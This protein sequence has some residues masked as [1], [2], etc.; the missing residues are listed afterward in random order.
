MRLHDLLDAVDPLELTGDSQVDVSDIVH[1]SRR[2]T[3]GALFCCIRGTAHDGHDHAAAAVERGAV[4]LLVERPVEVPVT[5]ARVGHV[6][7][8]LGPI[9]ARFFG[10]PSRA[11]RV[12]GVTGTNGKTT[13]TYLLEAI[14]IAA[15]ERVGVIG[16]TGARIDGVEEPLELTTPEAPQLQSL[17]ARMHRAR[18]GT[19]A[20]EVSSHALA[21]E[22]VDGSRF[23]AVCFTNLS[24]DHLDEHRTLAEYFEAKARLFT[25]AFTD[26]VTIGLDDRW[27]TELATRAQGAGLDVWTFGLD[28]RASV[29]GTARQLDADGSTIQLETSSGATETIRIPLVGLFNVQNALAAAAT[30]LAS[31][32]PLDAVLAGLQ[33][34]LVVPGRMERVTVGQPFTVLVDYAHTPGALERLVA[35]SRRLAGSNRVL[36]VFGCGGDR[37][38]TKRAAMGSAAADADLVVLTSDNP[39]SEEPAAI[40]AAAE[41][42]LRERD[43]SYVVELDRRQAIRHALG[44]ARANDVVVIAGKGHETGQEIAGVVTPFDDRVVAR[45]ELEALAGPDPRRGRRDHL[46]AGT[47]RPGRCPGSASTRGRLHAGLGSSRSEPSATVTTSSPTRSSRRSF[48]VVERFPT[49]SDGTFVVRWPTRTRRFGARC[50]GARPAGRPTVVGI[51]G[52]AGKT[53]TKDL[54]APRRSGRP[55]GARQRGVVQQRDR[56]SGDVARHPARHRGRRRRDGGALRREHHRAVHDRPSRRSVSSPTSASPTPSTSAAPTASPG[57]GRARRGAPADGLAVLSADCDFA[58]SSARTDARVLTVGSSADRRRSHLGGSARRRAAGQLPARFAVGERSRGPAR[59]PRCLPGR[60]R[61]PGRDRGP[62]S[63]GS[64]RGGG[65]GARRRRYR[66]VADGAGD[67]ERRCGGPQ[68]RLQREP[69][70]DAGRARYVRSPAGAAAGSRCSARCA[71]S[72]RLR[73]RSTRVGELVADA[74]S[75]CWSRWGP[76]FAP[77]SGRRRRAASSVT[78]AGCR[79]RR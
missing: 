50:R 24:Q 16:T 58:S 8:A 22:R 15:G 49:V 31:G 26:T 61:G 51:T 10:D 5:Q 69:E 40:A 20:M 18:V 3:R 36:V 30:A 45:E 17:L 9:A 72:V 41:V 39:R 28:P 63:R 2:A 60:E 74:G 73:R 38:P 35:E 34:E 11:M 29:R 37:D 46:R 53:S 47:D 21:Y 65:R 56:P 76:E 23:A 62:A 75:T 54:I 57:Q 25:P 42:G 59:G 33:T 64:A 1:D 67:L 7:S 78:G 52:S 70:L 68:R 44:E 77:S 12:L 79:R 43:A 6:R 55:P 32:F 19:V 27:G 13:T 48:A 71:S 4:A 66:G 14:A